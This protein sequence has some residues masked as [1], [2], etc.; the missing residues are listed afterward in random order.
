MTKTK[1]INKRIVDIMEEAF[2]MPLFFVA[3]VEALKEKISTM[4]DKD[5]TLIFGN[6][7]PATA[8][9]KKVDE[10][11]AILNDKDSLIS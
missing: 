3:G 11:H 7:I 8:I 9:R 5:V 2:M 10:I 4:D 1:T 6:L